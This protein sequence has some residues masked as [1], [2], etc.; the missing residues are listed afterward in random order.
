MSFHEGRR[1]AEAETESRRRDRRLRCAIATLE[2]VRQR[3]GR[4]SDP[5]IPDTD[6]HVSQAFRDR[7]FDGTTAG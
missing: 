6:G 4:D 5:V 3:V 2:E 1:D 7:H